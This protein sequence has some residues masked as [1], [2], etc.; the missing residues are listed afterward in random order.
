MRIRCGAT[1][2]TC[3]GSDTAREAQ[4][5]EAVKVTGCGQQGGERGRQ[6]RGASRGGGSAAGRRRHTHRTR[7][8]KDSEAHERKRRRAG[9][10]GRPPGAEATRRPPPPWPLRGSSPKKVHKPIIQPQIAPPP[11]PP[12]RFPT[13]GSTLLHCL[14]AP[15]PQKRSFLMHDRHAPRAPVASPLALPEPTKPAGLRSAVT[16]HPL[17]GS[18]FTNMP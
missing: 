15:A 2:D 14:H 18:R 1:R 9:K 5:G 13:G 16:I 4:R 17:V 7:R 11:T 6:G 8:A 3:H 10:P 12:L